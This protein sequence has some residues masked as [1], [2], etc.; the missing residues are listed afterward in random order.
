MGQYWKHLD[1][2]A[3][4]IL[5]LVVIGAIFFTGRLVADK[6]ER[7]EYENLVDFLANKLSSHPEDFTNFFMR[8]KMDVNVQ[9]FCKNIGANTFEEQKN[10]VLNCLFDGVCILGEFYSTPPNQGGKVTWSR[11][12][13]S[14]ESEEAKKLRKSVIDMTLRGE[15]K[16]R[17]SRINQ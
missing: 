2:I 6:K 7:S 17:F 14:P 11:I 3:G 10:L 9:M 15:M 8:L 1:L 12:S 5:L 13:F 16:L 4:V